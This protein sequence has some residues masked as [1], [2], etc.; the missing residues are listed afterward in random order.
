MTSYG[1]SI[2]TTKL[3]QNHHFLRKNRRENLPN[4]YYSDC[5]LLE[6]PAERLA[7]CWQQPPPD[8]TLP[9]LKRDFARNVERNLL[10]Q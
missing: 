5:P 6:I 9:S 4:S 7:R 8:L 2:F 1:N 10:H 3:V